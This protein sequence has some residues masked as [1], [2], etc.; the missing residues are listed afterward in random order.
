MDH[1]EKLI[2]YHSDLQSGNL[3]PVMVKKLMEKH[4]GVWVSGQIIPELHDYDGLSC[5][6]NYLAWVDGRFDLVCYL[7]GDVDKS[8]HSETREICIPGIDYYLL[9]PPIPS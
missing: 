4:A 6:D 7:N 1:L 8:W 5:S 2:S 9:A 3:R